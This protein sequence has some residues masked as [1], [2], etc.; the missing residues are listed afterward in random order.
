MEVERP[1]PNHGLRFEIVY[2]FLCFSIGTVV[3]IVMQRAFLINNVF[4]IIL[5]VAFLYQGW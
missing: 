1:L 2:V 3:T 5:H 4:S